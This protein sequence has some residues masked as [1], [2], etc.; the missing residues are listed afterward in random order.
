MTR[1]TLPYLTAT[2]LSAPARCDLDA[3]HPVPRADILNPSVA[4]TP[5]TNTIPAVARTAEFGPCM[6]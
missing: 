5:A 2:G 3:A 1:A 6:A 4:L